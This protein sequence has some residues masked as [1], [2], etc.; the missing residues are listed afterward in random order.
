[1][2]KMFILVK[3]EYIASIKTKGFIIGLIIAPIFM[4]GSLIVFSIMKDRVDTNDKHITVIDHSGLIYDKLVLLADERNTSEIFD[5]ETGKKIK[6]LYVINRVEISGGDLEGRKLELSES[7][8]NGELHAFV[9]ISQGVLNPSENPDSFSIYY[10]ANNAAMDDVRSWL[11][12]PINRTLRELRMQAAGIELTDIPDLFFWV[13]VNPMGLVTVDE[14]TGEISDAEK[15]SKIQA[16][17]VPIAIMMLMFLMMMMSVPGMLHSVM[18]EKTQR[19]AEV[20]LGSIKPFEFMMGK[21]LGG[22]AV[23]LTISGVYLIGGVSVVYYMG[24]D[25]FIPMKILPWLLVYLILA[26]IMMGALSAALGATCSEAKDAQSLTFP[27]MLPMF[28]PMFVYLPVVKEPLSSFSTII[29]LIPP[30]T[31]LLMLLRQATPETIPM[32]QPI[33]GLLGVILTTILFVWVG[34]RIFRVAI[35]MQGTPPKISNILR[36]A[37]KG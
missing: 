24:Y 34:G 23:S 36:W 21:V 17:L 4:S 30:F 14:E 9:E 31:P 26:V 28:V 35:L 20:L 5:E 18:E 12:W 8:R 7:V 19:I 15:A 27:S 2:R 1:M 37:I 6:P 13:D 10:Y 33:L 25:H 32:W 22:I 16:V 29:S 11:G 3:R